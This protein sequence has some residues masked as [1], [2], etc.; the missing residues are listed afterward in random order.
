MRFWLKR[1]KNCFECWQ[2]SCIHF[3]AESPL[4]RSYWWGDWWHQCPAVWAR[5]MAIS[6]VLCKAIG[7]HIMFVQGPCLSNS[8]NISYSSKTQLDSAM[9]H[10]SKSKDQS[11]AFVDE[12][13]CH[14]VYTPSVLLDFIFI[15]LVC[16]TSKWLKGIYNQILCS[17]SSCTQEK[18]IVFVCLFV[19]FDFVLFCFLFLLLIFFICLFVCLF[20]FVLLLFLFCFQLIN[21]AK[22][23]V[24]P[25]LL[26]DLVSYLFILVAFSTFYTLSIL[27]LFFFSFHLPYPY[28]HHFCA[29]S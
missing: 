9:V 1:I 22:S 23:V 27:Y 3:K 19:C 11:F 8:H 10:S 6:I 2:L 4:V 16:V 29:W 28:H 21:L 15:C 25:K 18:Y 13:S 26:Q 12:H 17:G 20:C 24:L 7:V 5:I 14:P